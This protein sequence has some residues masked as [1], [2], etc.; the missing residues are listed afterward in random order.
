MEGGR[1]P[2]PARISLRS[3]HRCKF[4][5]WEIGPTILGNASPKNMAE[6]AAGRPGLCGR[7]CGT[8]RNVCD[9][10][11]A[12]TWLGVGS[13]AAC[14]A[15]CRGCDR[16]RYVSFD[17]AQ[18]ECLWS[19][20]CERFTPDYARS[21][22]TYRVKEHEPND[23][24]KEV[25]SP[26]RSSLP[27]LESVEGATSAPWLRRAM[28]SR[29]V[30]GAR[31]NARLACFVRAASTRPVTIAS[32]GGSITAG[33]TFGFEAHADGARFLYHGVLER[34]MRAAFGG[35]AQ[36]HANL[37]RNLG[38]PACG[39]SLFAM[40]LPSL[41]PTPPDLVLLE[42]GVNAEVRTWLDLTWHDLA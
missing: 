27:S 41:L 20:K 39:P 37:S 17:G 22:T 25:G 40:C 16:C 34:W 2:P 18:S 29:G 11:M 3:C 33:L 1:E 8:V 28:L 36:P 14:V 35:A 23:E 4:A 10:G 15:R 6:D 12:G 5:Q 32:M 26:L 31:D 30:Q 9:R 19:H 38:I 24:P 42:F 7:A 21:F 13:L